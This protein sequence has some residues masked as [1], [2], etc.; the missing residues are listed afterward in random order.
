M[1]PDALALPAPT[2]LARAGTFIAVVGPSGAGKDTLIARAAERLAGEPTIRFVRR[3]VTRVPDG[4]SEDHDSLDEDSFQDA[5]ARG[6]FCLT[7]RAHGL[8][9]GLPRSAEVDVRRGLS[10]VANV[11]RRALEG[12][13]HRFGPIQVVEVTARPELLMARIAARGRESEAEV[14]HRLDRQVSV[15]IP[16]LTCGLLR[17]DNSDDLAEAVDLFV[18]HLITVARS[19]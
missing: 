16:A 7:W 5:E 11:S 18:R 3:V 12:A 9:Y 10:V 13:V 1:S 6:E 2:R 8:A 4:A 17:I 14:A 19:G 15:E